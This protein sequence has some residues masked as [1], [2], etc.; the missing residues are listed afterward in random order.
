MQSNDTS[1]TPFRVCTRI[2]CSHT[3]SFLIQQLGPAVYES[4][5]EWMHIT[6]A[7]TLLQ[8]QFQILPYSIQLTDSKKKKIFERLLSEEIM[9]KNINYSYN[10][11]AA[12]NLLSCET[13]VSK[14]KPLND[15][16][17]DSSTW[18]NHRPDFIRIKACRRNLLT[19]RNIIDEAIKELLELQKRYKAIAFKQAEVGL[20]HWCLLC[21]KRAIETHLHYC[22]QDSKEQYLSFCLVNANKGIQKHSDN[23]LWKVLA[24]AII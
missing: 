22:S 12:I 11:K 10:W 24:L 6:N 3:N 20:K 2:Y 21:G 8:V 18:S 23:R 13:V 15:V 5:T 14:Q 9:S 1:Q 16:D 19:I 4:S 17:D 7:P